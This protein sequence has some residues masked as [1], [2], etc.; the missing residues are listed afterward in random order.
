MSDDQAKLFNSLRASTA[1]LLGYDVDHLTAAQQIRLDRTITLRLLV[2]DLQARQLRGEMIDAKAFVAASE[3][4]ERLCGGQP[5]APATDDFADA[6]E[7]L[8]KLLERRAQ[9]IEARDEKLRDQ[10]QAREEQ[11]AIAAAMPSEPVPVPHIPAFSPELPRSNV[12]PLSGVDRANNNLPP[13]GYLKDGQPKEPWE[14]FHDG[15]AAGPHP[16]PLPQ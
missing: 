15:R 10:M 1:E 5:D 4:L 6:R 2:D 12:V 13:W 16:W 9:A 8:F 11:A 14:K 7:E 3:D